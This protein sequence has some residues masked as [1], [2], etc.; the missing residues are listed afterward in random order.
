M[1]KELRLPPNELNVAADNLHSLQSI[2][3][4]LCCLWANNWIHRSLL[5]DNDIKVNI[6]LMQQVELHFAVKKEII[7]LLFID[8]VFFIFISQYFCRLFFNFFNK[9]FYFDLTCFQTYSHLS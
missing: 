1:A 5:R 3:T 6:Y 7:I 4:M 8:N 2:L 9:R